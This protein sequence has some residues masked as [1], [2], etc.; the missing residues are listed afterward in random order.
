MYLKMRWVMYRFIL[1]NCKTC[2]QFYR[3][4][5]YHPHC[6]KHINIENA[7]DPLEQCPLWEEKTFSGIFGYLNTHTSNIEL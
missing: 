1:K 5:N 3:D 2:K 6:R 7:I 4:G